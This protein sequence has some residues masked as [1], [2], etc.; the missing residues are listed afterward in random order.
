MNSY[1]I[2]IT[3]KFF[4]CPI[5]ITSLLIVWKKVTCYLLLFYYRFQLLLFEIKKN[6]I[7]IDKLQVEIKVFFII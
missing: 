1:S 7:V 4:E 3:F 2:I 6:S 5:T